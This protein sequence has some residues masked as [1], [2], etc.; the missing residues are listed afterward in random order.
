MVN[1]HD[2]VEAALS[3]VDYVTFLM[4]T[5]HCEIELVKPDVL[6]KGGDYVPA[7]IVGNDFVAA[8]GGKTVIINLV[9][10]KSTTN[11]VNRMQ[12]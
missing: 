2:R 8:R 5:H 12:A 4:K 1:Q 10:G 6:V 7:T 11:I 3:S 9:D